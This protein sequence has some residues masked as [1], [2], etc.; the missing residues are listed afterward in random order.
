MTIR[1]D[2]SIDWDLSP[3]LLTVASPSTEITVQDLYDTCKYLEDSPN[4]LVFDYLIDAG[5]KEPIGATDFVGIT[6]TLNNAVLAFEARGGPSWTLCI[7][8]GGNLVAVDDNGDPIDPRYPTDYI[9]V[10]RAL[11]SSPTISEVDSGSGLTPS[12]Q[13][14]LS[15]IYTKTQFIHS[16]EGGRWKIDTTTNQ[17]IFYDEDNVTEI[18]RFNLFDSNGVPASDDVF[19]R[20]RITTTTSTTTTTTS[21]T[22]TTT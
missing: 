5:G 14:Q 2:V 6:A 20:V 16:M 7:I 11:S 22:T 17:M 19:E 18:A 12:E 4:G 3:R 21:T 10:D 13:A 9:T 1:S 8:S 15:D